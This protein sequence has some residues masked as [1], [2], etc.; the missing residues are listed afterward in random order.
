[1]ACRGEA[2]VGNWTVVVRDTVSN[3]NHGELTDWRLTLWGECIDA[4]RAVKAPMPTDHD[5]DDH[6]V[7]IAIVGT[8]TVAPMSSTSLPE[9]PTDHPDRPVNQRPSITASIGSPS[10]TESSTGMA[11]TTPSA[12]A[13]S[14]FLL[15]SIFPTFGVSPRTQIWIYGAVGTMIAFCLGLGTYF[16]VL[17]RR[18]ARTSRADYEFEMLDDQ[19]RDAGK[20]LSGGG[21]VKR[22]AGELYDAFAGESDEE[23]FSDGEA[24]GYRD[25]EELARLAQGGSG[26]G[27]GDGRGTDRASEDGR[28]VVESEE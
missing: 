9:H 26:A 2:G 27:S 15:P 24:D 22:R 14:S 28:H 4:A 19:D 18:R 10:T 8:T 17:R 23:M 5:D 11:D 21:R 20:P 3:D 12:T 16:C 1:M 25:E 7:M 13:T 6:D